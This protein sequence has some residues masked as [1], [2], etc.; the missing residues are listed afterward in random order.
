MKDGDGDRSNDLVT[1]SN[2]GS[3]APTIKNDEAETATSI[4]PPSTIG[5]V[6]HTDTATAV[7][8]IMHRTG[9]PILFSSTRHAGSWKRGLDVP[10]PSISR[11][12]LGNTKMRQRLA[13][14]LPLS[15]KSMY[16]ASS[17]N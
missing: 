7:G 9:M 5:T 10:F 12:H 17:L 16:V 11:E 3:G 4:P 14:H 2:G 15:S 1:N 8:D 13:T 6:A